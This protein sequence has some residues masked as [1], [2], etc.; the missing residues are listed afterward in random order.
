MQLS[1]HGRR[2]YRLEIETVPQ[3]VDWEASFDRGATWHLGQRE[4]LTLWW[5]W[6]VAGDK[7][8]LGTAVAALSPGETKVTVRCVD[9]PEIEATDAPSIY[10]T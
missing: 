1:R 5:Q 6:L 2:Y 9:T 3:L 8:P 10:V 4:G 7:A